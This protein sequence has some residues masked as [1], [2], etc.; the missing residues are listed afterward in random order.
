MRSLGILSTESTM[1]VSLALVQLQM[2]Q[3]L[4]DS[5]ALRWPQVTVGMLLDLVRNSELIDVMHP[6]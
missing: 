4:G 3:I 1:N 2:L 5:W 6:V